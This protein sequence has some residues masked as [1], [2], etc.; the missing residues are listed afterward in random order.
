MFEDGIITPSGVRVYSALSHNV[1]GV[2]V[3]DA[4]DIQTQDLLRK[5]SGPQGRGRELFSEHSEDAL[6]WSLF[7]ALSKLP[8]KAWLVDLLRVSVNDGLAKRYAPYAHLAEVRFWQSYKPSRGYV[9]WLNAKIRREGEAAFAHLERYE[10]QVRAKRRLARVL[11]G[12]TAECER[13][14]EVDI[15]IALGKELKIVIEAKLTSDLGARG[16]FSPP[17]RNQLIRNCEILADSAQEEGFKDWR[18]ILLTMDRLPDKLYTKTMKRYRSPDMRAL[19]RW[20]E[21]GN[22]IHLREDMMHRAQEPED[23]F[24][25]MSCRMGWCLWTD[26]FKLLAHYKV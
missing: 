15:Q 1:S 8:T 6:T 25:N 19:R 7:H 3:T 18:F 21:P 26:I 4:E 14:T 10:D 2:D 11:D 23:Y 24:L 9:E 13:P 20:D 12:D 16:T 22:T 5:Y 17:G